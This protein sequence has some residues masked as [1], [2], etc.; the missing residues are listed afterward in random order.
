[1]CVGCGSIENDTVSPR[2]PYYCIPCPL[3]SVTYDNGLGGEIFM[4]KYDARLV[5]TEDES[6]YV[7]KMYEPKMP[8]IINENKENKWGSPRGYKVRARE[9]ELDATGVMRR[10]IVVLQAVW[11]LHLCQQTVCL[12]VAEVHQLLVTTPSFVPLCMQLTHSPVCRAGP[13][14]K[15]SGQPGAK[16]ISKECRTW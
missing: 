9:R 1:M 2:T 10:E 7:Q 16:V 11:E 14:H 12:G 6:G 5:E 4:N 3:Q 13:T 8:I 15:A